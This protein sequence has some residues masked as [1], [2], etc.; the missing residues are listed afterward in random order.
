MKHFLFWIISFLL[1]S[2]TTLNGQE[3]MTIGEVFDYHIGDEFHFMGQHPEQPP[4]ADRITIIDKYYSSAGDTLLYVQAVDGYQ[5]FV[6]WEPEPHLV[7]TFWKDTVITW[8]SNLELTIDQYDEGFQYDTSIYT[9]DQYCNTL[10]NECNYF[11]GEFEPDHYINTYGRGLGRT[12]AYLEQMGYMIAYDQQMFYYNKDGVECGTPD[13]ITV[14]IQEIM[15]E[16]IFS[17]YPNPASTFVCI[18]P[19]AGN[20]AFHCKLFNAAGTVLKTFNLAHSAYTLDIR[21]LPKGI[22]FVS[23]AGS[24]GTYTRKLIVE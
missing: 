20:E 21:D 10:M 15:D 17:I 9:S 22:Y 11:V 19:V 6:E 16:V 24:K 1:I 2:S 7:Y 8:V 5:S 4:N 12:H 13:T 18:K 14:G 23:Y 3:L